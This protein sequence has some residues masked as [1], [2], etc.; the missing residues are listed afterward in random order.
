MWGGGGG[1]PAHFT[2][3]S[4][5]SSRIPYRA[6]SSISPLFHTKPR[7]SLFLP[8]PPPG[9]LFLLYIIGQAGAAGPVSIYFVS[10]VLL[11]P[12][13]PALPLL[14]AFSLPTPPTLQLL[15]NKPCQSGWLADWL[16]ALYIL[17]VLLLPTS[18]LPANKKPWSDRRNVL[19]ISLF[20][21]LP[22]PQLL[23]SKPCLSD[24]LA[25]W[26]TG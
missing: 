11:L 2:V 10:S 6:S 25:D 24:R 5:R 8:F 26:L 4:F 13:L 23:A 12:D 20:P 14:H 3:L 16:S 21:L 22:T 18:Q 7:F 19:E 9:T 17:L 1:G 15:A